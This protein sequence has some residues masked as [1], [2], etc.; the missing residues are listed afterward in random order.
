M[1]DYVP[2]YRL[3][4]EATMKMLAAGI[5]RADELGV[6]I[7]LAVCN[8]S[9]EIIG[10]LVMDGAKHFAGR[11]TTKKAKTAASQREPT[12]YAEE[13]RVL[14]M[15]IR[16]DGEFTNVR[17]GFP[18]V[19]EGQVIGGVGAGGAT[20]DQDVAIAQAALAALKL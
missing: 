10:Y 12:G 5:A 16:M 19:V 11:T 7:A 17:G 20:Q 18:I 2:T 15:Q 3:T 13:H 14:S 9:C 1:P 6:R 4:H 8:Q